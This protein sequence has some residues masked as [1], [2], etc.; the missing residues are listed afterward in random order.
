MGAKTA[1]APELLAEQKEGVLL[2]TLNRPEVLNSLTGAMLSGLSESLKKAAK[3]PGVRSVILTAKGRAFCA[4]ADLADLRARQKGT[5]VSLGDELRRHFN[6]LILQIRRLEKP[7]IG[8][9]NG[10]AAGAGA[11]L[12]LS[13]DIK[14]AAP[15]SRFILAFGQVGLVPDSGMTYDLPRRMGLSLALEY[16]WTGRPITADRALEFGLVNRVAASEEE[17]L[18]LA[19]DMAR[20]LAAKAPLAVGMAKRAMNRA[21]DNDLEAQLEYEAELQETLGKTKDHAEGVAAFLEK[22]KPAFKGE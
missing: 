13:C 18:A 15:H 6:P 21:F 12:I 3:D 7:V 8:A 5:G 9:V 14:I 17:T 1:A 10:L 11:S 16:A 2:L 4:G 20:Q 19:W 22:R